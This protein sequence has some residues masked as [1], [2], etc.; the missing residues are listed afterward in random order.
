M[1]YIQKCSLWN[2]DEQDKFSSL[3]FVLTPVKTYI[4]DDDLVRK[5]FRCTECEQL[6]FYEYI[7]DTDWNEGND[8]Q[9]RTL[10]PVDSENQADRMS[11]MSEVDILRFSPRLQNDWSKDA[12][13]KTGWFWSGK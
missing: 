12:K 5:L 10:I 8:P 13:E 6:Y 3:P 7:E 11:K 2:I 1:I 9:Y 4:E